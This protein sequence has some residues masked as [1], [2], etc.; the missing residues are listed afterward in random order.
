MARP[1]TLF[2]GQ[3]ADLKIEDMARMTR[4]FGYDGIELACWGD[5]FEVDKAIAEDDYCSAKRELLDSHGPARAVLPQRLASDAGAAP[6]GRAH[7]GSPTDV[8]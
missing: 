4:E 3:W 6:P 2:T 8:A 1:V 5:P 7:V